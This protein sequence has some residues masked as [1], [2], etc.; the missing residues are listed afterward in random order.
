MSDAP[1][2]VHC[3]KSAHFLWP[4]RSRSTDDQCPY[5][6]DERIEYVERALRGVLGAIADGLDVGGYVYW[7][8]LDN[9]EWAYGYK[10]TFGLVAVDRTDQARAEKPSA[11]WLGRIARANALG[12][13][14]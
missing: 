9:F 11:R 4:T 14:E 8:L 3:Q 10:P 6:G 12:A 1:C 2:V 7:S 13:G 5:N